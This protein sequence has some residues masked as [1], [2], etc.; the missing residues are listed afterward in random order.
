MMYLDLPKNEL[1]LRMRAGVIT[2]LGNDARESNSEMYKRFYFV[3]WVVL[4]EHKKA[5]LNK[6]EVIADAQWKDDINWMPADV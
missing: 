2:N 6:I 1:Q 5:M 4:N 3:D